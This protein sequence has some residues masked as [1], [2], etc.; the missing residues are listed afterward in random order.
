MAKSHG[1]R[2]SFFDYI[3]YLC[4]LRRRKELTSNKL[5]NILRK[6]LNFELTNNFYYNRLYNKKGPIRF[7]NETFIKRLA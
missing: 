6:V 2:V 7:I 4:G 5:K 3:Y 1:K